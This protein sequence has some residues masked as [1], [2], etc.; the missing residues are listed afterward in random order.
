MLIN[1]DHKKLLLLNV[2]EKK[3]EVIDEITHKN[4]KSQEE[5]SQQINIDN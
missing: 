5:P 1:V 2:G 3:F 4:T